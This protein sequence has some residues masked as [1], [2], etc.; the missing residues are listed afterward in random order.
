MIMAIGGPMG[1]A[2]GSGERAL[3]RD[4]AVASELGLQFGIVRDRDTRWGWLENL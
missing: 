3:T 4:P 2:I 1:V